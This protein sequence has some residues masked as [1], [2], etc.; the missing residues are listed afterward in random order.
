MIARSAHV[1][2]V[3]VPHVDAA[4]AF[5]CVP[6]VVAAH[7]GPAPAHSAAACATKNATTEHGVACQ[8]QAVEHCNPA[9]NNQHEVAVEMLMNWEAV[10]P[11]QGSHTS[12]RVNS[13]AAVPSKMSVTM[14]VWKCSTLIKW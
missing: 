14:G 7:A 1:F 12:F 4:P 6:F 3:W 11:G 9:V 10:T 5:V 8:Q 2:A 13:M